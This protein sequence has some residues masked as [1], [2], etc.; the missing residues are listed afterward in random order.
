METAVGGEGHVD[1]CL[2]DI[3]ADHGACGGGA[4]DGGAALSVEV[5]VAEAIYGRGDGNVLTVNI[6]RKK[7]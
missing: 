1:V 2:S 5:D 3:G 7:T 6:M 4:G